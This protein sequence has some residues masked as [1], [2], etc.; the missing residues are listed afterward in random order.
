MTGRTLARAYLRALERGDLDEILA[1]F[2]PDAV[3]HSPLYGPAPA[4]EFY[5]RL[6]ADTGSAELHLRGA[7]EGERLVGVWFRFDWTLPS[8]TPAGFEC[9]DMLELDGDGLIT[10]LRIFYDTVTTRTAFERETG[11]SWRDTP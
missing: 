4:A 9:V 10:T 8:G 7:T 6:L 3:V 1:L 2:H 11:G 5:P